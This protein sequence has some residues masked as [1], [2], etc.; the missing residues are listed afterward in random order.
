MTIEFL[1]DFTT[2]GITQDAQLDPADL[3]GWEVRGFLAKLT[4]A[5]DDNGDAVVVRERIL[6]PTTYAP[7]MS[8]ELN[9]KAQPLD[10]DGCD[11]P[12]PVER[13]EPYD[14]EWYQ[15]RW[16]IYLIFVFIFLTYKLVKMWRKYRV[17]EAINMRKQERD[18]MV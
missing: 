7:V 14:P 11:Y 5:T 10:C 12:E 1:R 15:G 3:Q 16:E 9:L 13:Y 17:K 6:T 18:N 4:A 8:Y 2:W